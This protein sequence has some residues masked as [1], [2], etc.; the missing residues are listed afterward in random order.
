MTYQTNI[1]HYNSPYAAPYPY[2]TAHPYHYPHPAYPPPVI[3]PPPYSTVDKEAREKQDKINKR[4]Q[5]IYHKQDKAINA[6]KD[7]NTPSFPKE[8]HKS[9]TEL[10]NFDGGRFMNRGATASAN[11]DRSSIDN[12]EKAGSHWSHNTDAGE[13]EDKPSDTTSTADG[14]GDDN[15]QIEVEDIMA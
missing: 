10:M 7:I 5:E 6:A 3:P 1:N 15:A 12:T 9:I 8:S 14:D 11:N 13:D 4:L 2:P